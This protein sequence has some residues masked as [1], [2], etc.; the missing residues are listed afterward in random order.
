MDSLVG[1]VVLSGGEK[2][3]IKY[4]DGHT[5]K[6]T[7]METY[8]YTHRFETDD[9]REIRLANRFMDLRDIKVLKD[10]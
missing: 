10:E 1:S 9:G 3:I 4:S 5:V 8:G 6:A 2:V 7:Y